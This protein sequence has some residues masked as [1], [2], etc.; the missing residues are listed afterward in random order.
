MHWHWLDSGAATVTLIL[1][2][3]ALAAWGWR[4]L[5]HLS[6]IVKLLRQLA[7]I[8]AIVTNHEARIVALELAAAATPPPPAAP[9]NVN[10]NPAPLA[11]P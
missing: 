11:S 1:G 10:V 2:I 9:V 7:N 4:V 8:P 3:G 6:R 5:R